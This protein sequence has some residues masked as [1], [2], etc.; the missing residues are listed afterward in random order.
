MKILLFDT[1]ETP[2][3]SKSGHVI[4]YAG[5]SAD[6]G[7]QIV[8]YVECVFN[9]SGDTVTFRKNSDKEAARFEPELKW[10]VAYAKSVNIHEVYAVFTIN[11]PLDLA[12]IRRI[13]P[14]G[15]IDCRRNINATKA[16]FLTDHGDITRK[17]SELKPAVG[18]KLRRI[19][20]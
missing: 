17:W 9:I 19:L 13:C 15:L 12:V 4:V 7:N 8:T 5:I 18:S 10:A 2:T 14:K 1:M 16:P 3:Q 11:R 6:Y 20:G